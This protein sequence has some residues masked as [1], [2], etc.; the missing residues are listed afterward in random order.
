MSHSCPN[1][2][3]THNFWVFKV[4][5]GNLNHGMLRNALGGTESGYGN[6]CLRN[7]SRHGSARQETCKTRRRM[8][9]LG[10][11]LQLHDDLVEADEV[12]LIKA[13]IIPKI[14]AHRRRAHASEGPEGPFSRCFRCPA[15]AGFRAFRG[16]T[17][18]TSPQNSL[19]SQEIPR[20]MQQNWKPRL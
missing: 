3:L 8:S 1:L 19:E 9:A 6:T 18:C 12:W 11:G 14:S 5:C 2:P 7:I 10:N 15:N 20:W 13:A 16:Q 4:F 17:T